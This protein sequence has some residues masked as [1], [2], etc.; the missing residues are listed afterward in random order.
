MRIEAFEDRKMFDIGAAGPD[1]IAI[2]PNEGDL[3][4]NNQTLHV[5]PR[6]LL[7]RFE[8]GSVIN[9]STLGGIQIVRSG[10]DGV[11]GVGD[12]TVP[13]GFVGIGEHPNEVIVRF[14]ENLPDDLYR[15]TVRASGQGRVTGTV[16]A[17]PPSPPGPTAQL[18]VNGG[19]DIVQTFDLDLAPKLS[20]LC[21]N[22]SLVAPTTN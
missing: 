3:I 19:T 6:E 11:F 18:P 9:P 1:L 14:A 2:I 17:N 16:P 10:G 7:F 12:V 15:I 5:A 22:Q 4:Q 21:R 13:I 20:L 8:D